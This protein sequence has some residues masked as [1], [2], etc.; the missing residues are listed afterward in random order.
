MKPL[1]A[2]IFGFSSAAC[3]AVVEIWRVQIGHGETGELALAGSLIG[4]VLFGLLYALVIYCCGLALHFLHRDQE[5]TAAY[6]VSAVVEAPFWLIILYIHGVARQKLLR[7]DK[8]WLV[9]AIV[10][11]ALS[12]EVIRLVDR[13]CTRLTRRCSQP[14]TG[15]KTIP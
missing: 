7:P 9:E 6:A 5:L 4:L 3:A 14:P 13:L 15:E 2:I 8:I 1:S 10:L 11:C 12:F